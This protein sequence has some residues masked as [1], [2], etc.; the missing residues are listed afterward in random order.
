MSLP[1]KHF[2][3]INSNLQNKENPLTPIVFFSG[4][5]TVIEGNGENGINHDI[6]P[7][8]PLTNGNHEHK[9]G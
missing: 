7:N 4:L 8:P 1:S 5:Q 9:Q 3:G 2:K 6:E